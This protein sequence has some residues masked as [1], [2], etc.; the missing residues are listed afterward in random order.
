MRNQYSYHP[1]NA[2]NFGKEI[3]RAFPKVKRQQRRVGRSFERVYCGLVVREGSEVAV[4][5]ARHP[6]QEQELGVGET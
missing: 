6:L 4:K 5:S 3:K 1:L 2:S